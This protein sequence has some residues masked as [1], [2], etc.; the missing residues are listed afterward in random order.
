[1]REELF[2]HDKRDKNYKM[3]IF[4]T[5]SNFDFD[6]KNA[7]IVICVLSKIHIILTKCRHFHLDKIPN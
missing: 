5:I 6:K 3:N 1:M 2:V 7:K 4:W